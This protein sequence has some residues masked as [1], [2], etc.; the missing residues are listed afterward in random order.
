MLY[1]LYF[2]NIINIDI[3]MYVRSPQEHQIDRNS[4]NSSKNRDVLDRSAFLCYYVFVKET[5]IK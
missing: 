1:F 3:G 2:M 4:E 5:C